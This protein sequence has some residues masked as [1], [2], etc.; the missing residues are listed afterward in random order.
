MI[1]HSYKIPSIN[2]NTPRLFSIIHSKRCST[3][4]NVSSPPKREFLRDKI[5]RGVKSPNFKYWFIGGTAFFSWMS[6]YGI[7][8]YKKSRVDIEILPPLPTHSTITRN[9]DIANLIDRYNVQTSFFGDEKIKKLMIM[10]TSG[11][12]KTVLAYDLAKQVV[13]NVIYKYCGFPKSK[14]IVFLHGDSEES[15]LLSLKAFAARFKV[16]SSE[17][18]EAIDKSF[19]EASF[20]EQCSALLS[21]IRENLKR[22]PD[23]V[24]V[25]DNVQITSPQTVF[26]TVNKWFLSDEEKE[27]WSRGSL[28]VVHDGIE[29]G[30]LK[31]PENLKHVNYGMTQT[32]AY[33]L[34]QDLGNI[35]QNLPMSNSSQS[36]INKLCSNPLATVCAAILL[37]EKLS[38]KESITIDTAIG[39]LLTQIDENVEKVKNDNTHLLEFIN[40]KPG[41]KLVTIETLVAMTMKHLYSKDRYIWHGFDMLATIKPGTPVPQTLI[42]RYLKNPLFK[43]PPLA[44]G[45]SH[46]EFFN[47]Q[48]NDLDI[49]QSKADEFEPKGKAWS[50]KNLSEYY[51]KVE[52][53]FMSGITIVKDIYNLVYGELPELPEKPDGLDMFRSCPLLQTNLVEP[54]DVKTISMHPLVYNAARQ[55]FLSTTVPYM[56]NEH[57]LA[58]QLRHLNQSWYKRLSNFNEQACLHTLRSS[59]GHQ[60]PSTG[61]PNEINP[62]PVLARYNLGINITSVYKFEPFADKTEDFWILKD[63][64]RYRYLQSHIERV[65]TA[66]CDDI[67]VTKSD[68]SGRS[69]KCALLSHLQYILNN[70]PND[71]FGLP[72]QIE[73]YQTV[74]LLYK[75]LYSDFVRSLSLLEDTLQLQKSSNANPLDIAKTISRIASVHQGKEEYNEA[76][77]LLEEASEYHEAD[78]RKVGEYK[79]SLEFGKLLGDLGVVY[80]ALNMKIEAKEAIERSLMLKQVTPPDLSDEAKSKQYGADFSSSLTDLGHSYVSLGM[81]LYGKKILDLALAAQKNLLGEEHPEVVRTITILAV[82]HLMQGHNEES[83]KLRFEAG[84]LQASI[85]ALPTY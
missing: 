76:R 37:R 47:K 63:I 38:Q 20:D 13:N 35:D 11:S 77:T 15:F 48:K 65:A 64:D 25:L 2:P 42:A 21:C 84:K 52:E 12:G 29:R 16:K 28:L 36:L 58:D 61:Q 62:Q 67:A 57:L 1:R 31:I 39:D 68:V 60:P 45:N 70:H 5:K 7:K 10:G 82:A 34:L 53:F 75:S 71:L 85:N 22:H 54:G 6:Y 44:Q 32:D 73:S 3:V 8:S 14:V 4:S 83:K 55:F 49:V 18:S 9:G 23:W 56:E 41:M 27:G 51:T 33:R 80:G 19:N 66:L 69:T 24:V 78:R 50:N 81:P 74:A 72:R 30:Q 40:T 59:I 17:L 43:L 79:E 26:N 46:T